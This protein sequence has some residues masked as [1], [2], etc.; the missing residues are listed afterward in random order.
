MG[1]CCWQA[2]FAGAAWYLLVGSLTV[3]LCGQVLYLWPEGCAPIIQYHK[4]MG[5]Y[6][7]MCSF[8]QRS[9]QPLLASFASCLLNL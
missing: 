8:A 9:K 7:A 4:G 1:L 6:E 3:T 2:W 5:P